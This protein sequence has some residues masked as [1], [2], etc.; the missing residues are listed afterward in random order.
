M[1]LAIVE[2]HKGNFLTTNTTDFFTSHNNRYKS[3]KQFHTFTNMDIF[4][5]AMLYKSF[6]QMVLMEPTD[7]HSLK[8]HPSNIVKFSPQILDVSVSN[9]V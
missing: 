6:T 2:R 3:Y 4:C 7:S 1:L 8:F 9:T 5:L